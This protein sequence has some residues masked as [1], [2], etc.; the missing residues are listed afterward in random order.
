MP[1][2][3]DANDASLDS[4]LRWL[5]STRAWLAKRWR[6]GYGYRRVG[7]HWR[8][9]GDERI[10]AKPDSPGTWGRRCLTCQT[11]DTRRSW[12]YAGDAKLDRSVDTKKY[13]YSRQAHWRCPSCGAR[14]FHVI[15]LRES[16]PSS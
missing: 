2:H 8:K 1:D 4:L 7:D 9:P 14:R 10:V 5:K 3:P 12:K 11:I 13:W 6:M 16:E 15:E